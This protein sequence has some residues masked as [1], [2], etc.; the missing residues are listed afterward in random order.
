M[1]RHRCQEVVRFLWGIGKK[2]CGGDY[3]Y[4]I[5]GKGIIMIC[6]DCEHVVK[7]SRPPPPPPP[8]R[9]P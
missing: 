1:G 8:K 7:V 9:K 3:D 5:D 6:R 2:I 4:G